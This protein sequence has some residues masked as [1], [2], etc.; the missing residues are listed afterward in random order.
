MNQVV[1]LERVDVAGTEWRKAVPRA[2]E[3]QRSCS[4]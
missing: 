3:Q 4:S 2:L 1:E